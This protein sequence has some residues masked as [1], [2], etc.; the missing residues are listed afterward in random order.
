MGPPLEL[1]PTLSLSLDVLFLS[2]LSFH[3]SQLF[4]MPRPRPHHAPKP[5][6]HPFEQIVY[7]AGGA[8]DHHVGDQAFRLTTGGMLVVPPDV[9]HYAEVVGDEVLVNFDIFTPRREEYVQ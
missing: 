6:A 4:P 7:I 3:S 8:C 2:F 1:D 5:H 9:E